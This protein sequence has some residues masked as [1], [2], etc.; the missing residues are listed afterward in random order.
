MTPLI[1]EVDRRVRRW[2]S[3]GVG[4]TWVV[5]VSGGGD[6][7]AL[8][9]LLAGARDRLGITLSI[10][11]L[12]HSARGDESEADQAFVRELA[13]QLGLPLDIGRWQAPTRAGFEAAARKAR[14][15]WLISVA[16]ERKAS[17]IAVGHTLDDQAETILHRIVRGTGVRGITGMS[18]LR[19]LELTPRLVLARPLLGSRR[20]DLR[21][22]LSGLGQPHR[23]DSSNTDMKGTRARLRHQLL[24]TIA[25]LYNR[26]IMDALARLG[27]SARCHARMV[28]EM[29]DALEPGLRVPDLSGAVVFRRLNLAIMNPFMRVELFRGTW[30]DQGWPERSMT[31]EHWRRIGQLGTR[32]FD[33]PREVGGGVV[34]VVTR[35]Y[36]I[37]RGPNLAKAGDPS[38]PADH[39]IIPLKIPGTAVVPWA[40]GSITSC[41]EPVL[42]VY[43]TLDLEK[44]IPPLTIDAPRPGD[45][46]DPLGMNGQTTPLADFFRG[47][48]LPRPQR[49]TVPIVRDQRGIIWVVGHRIC[50]HA[51]VTRETL[52][53]LGL[54]F[55]AHPPRLFLD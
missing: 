52:H 29:T 6:S 46:F 2:I 3:R 31:A 36:V 5:A 54:R 43:E 17:V 23:E 12:N 48:K 44:I 16:R 50:H 4:R 13:D 55:E 15:Q 11:H 41:L 45:R 51:R 26:R 47:R 30:R 35:D 40:F 32:L 38:L 19:R 1:Q 22:Y 39:A 42:K 28:E 34:A 18:G 14:Y 20:E 33:T 8:A 37:L 10:A 49:S 24:P 25:A 9:R 21:H 53:T 27:E 7:V